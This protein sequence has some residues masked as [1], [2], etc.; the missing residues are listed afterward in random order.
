M[1]LPT[2]CIRKYVSTMASPIK[3]W[4]LG[5]VC[6]PSAW[7]R[8]WKTISRRV[9]GVKATSSAGKSVNRLNRTTMFQGTEP[10][11]PPGADQCN[12]EACLGRE[13][14][15]AATFSTRGNLLAAVH[16]ED[17]SLAAINIFQPA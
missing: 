16:S 2:G 15:A 5:A 6:V 10:V 17:A 1:A 7:R 9:K 4:L 14:Q 12:P 8:K 13:I 11:A 3:V